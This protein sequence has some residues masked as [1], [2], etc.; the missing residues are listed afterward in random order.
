[1]YCNDDY[2]RRIQFDK[3]RILS[4]GSLSSAPRL[5]W[6]KLIAENGETYDSRAYGHIKNTPRAMFS[7]RVGEVIQIPG[8]AEPLF[9][10]DIMHL[11]KTVEVTIGITDERIAE[12]VLHDFCQNGKLIISTH[13]NLYYKVSVMETAESEGLSRHFS[14]IKIVYAA[15]AYRYLLDEPVIKSDRLAVDGVLA[16]GSLN[17]TPEFPHSAE[18]SEPL[19]YIAT[20]NGTDFETIAAKIAVDSGEEFKIENMA[21]GTIYCVDSERLSAYI[22]GTIDTAGN[23]TKNPTFEDVTCKTTGDFPQMGTQ[24][25]HVICYDGYISYIGVKPNARWNV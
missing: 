3:R 5:G 12:N 9:T 4:D 23:V 18:P 17:F 8:R 7:P 24:K 15:S 20:Q 11:E 25:Q 19:I 10:Q 1:M 16:S 2:P 22:Y 13:P 6:V 14:E 21:A